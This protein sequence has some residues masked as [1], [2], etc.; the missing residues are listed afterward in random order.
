MRRVVVFYAMMFCISFVNAQSGSFNIGHGQDGV[1]AMFLGAEM[2]TSELFSPKTAQAQGILIGGS[3]FVE[4]S[5]L[6]GQITIKSKDPLQPPQALKTRIR[7]NTYNNEFE[8]INNADTLMVTN[9]QLIKEIQI[10]EAHYIYT[11]CAPKE[12]L[13]EPAY[14]EVLSDG[15]VKLLKRYDCEIEQNL[16]VPY[17]MG[18]NGDGAYYYQKDI[19]YYIKRGDGN[20][21]KMPYSINKTTKIFGAKR[22]LAKAKIKQDNLKIRKNEEDLVELF[23]YMNSMN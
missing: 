11:L 23:Q 13:I 21:L 6:E 12:N 1:T 15:N 10:E 4:E 18:G 20:A 7:F 19:D 14:M 5:F 22:N 3:P 9:P 8:F 16:S 2:A 17:Y